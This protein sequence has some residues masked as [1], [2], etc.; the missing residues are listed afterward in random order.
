L[1]CLPWI[2]FKIASLNCV[3]HGK[4]LSTVK[5]LNL[6]LSPSKKQTLISKELTSK[7]TNNVMRLK[8]NSFYIQWNLLFD[9]SEIS[10]VLTS[11]GSLV[12]EYYP[13]VESRP[14]ATNI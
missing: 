10:V 2:I 8:T 11:I 7:P 6:S 13:C 9:R 12:Y 5:V 3:A 4:S 14:R 1:T